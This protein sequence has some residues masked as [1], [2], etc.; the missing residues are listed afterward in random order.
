MLGQGA[1]R[2][3]WK[4]MKMLKPIFV[5]DYPLGTNKC[6]YIKCIVCTRENI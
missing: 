3:K 2:N 5:S 1:G 6:I 4:Y